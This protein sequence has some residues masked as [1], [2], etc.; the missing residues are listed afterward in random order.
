MGDTATIRVF[1]VGTESLVVTLSGSVEASWADRLRAKLDLAH[2]RRVIVD[3]LDATYVDR[4]V[5]AVLI[6]AAERSPLT[7]VAQPRLLHVF[8]LTRISR[9]LR[10][11]RSLSDAVAASL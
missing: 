1:E 5:Q 10:L 6:H 3:L 4:D 11:D 7:V 2:R 8:E 9:A